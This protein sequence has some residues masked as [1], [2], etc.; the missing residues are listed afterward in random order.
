MI[1]VNRMTGAGRVAVAMS[2]GVDSSVTAALLKDQGYEVI[3]ISMRVWDPTAFF[4]GRE[5]EAQT[6]C[7]PDDVR[8]AG[9]IADQL[10]IPFYV[11]NFEEAFRSL[12]VDDF[13]SEY[14]R[15]RTPNPCARCNRLVKFGL[16]LDK[17]VELGADSMATGHYARIEQG[18]DG[19]HHLL[20]GVDP[21]KD[22]S[23][24][25]FGLT[26][27]Q[28]SRSLFPLGALTKPEVRELANRY[29]LRVAEKK[30]SQEICF[31]PDDDYVRFIEA[32]QDPGRLSGDIVTREGT[33]VGRHK[34]THRYTVGQ[35]RGLGI[36]WRE[37]LYVLA[38]DAVRRRVIVG[39][40][41]ELCHSG[42]EAAD[43]NWIMPAPKEELVT[44]CRIRYRHQ[45]VPC[46][47][48][49]LA[50]NRVTVHFDAPEKSITPGQAVVFYDGDRVLGGGWIERAI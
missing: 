21:K 50:D 16:L 46:R 48:V 3:G 43:M 36:A 13:V 40:R 17:A 28:L 5:C 1:E 4:A 27:A 8:D 6:C 26:Q 37:P 19:F 24:F 29:G 20:K 34:G 44:T 42:L 35:R 45:P 15:G 38:V 14:Y 23:Y 47:V 12:V 18:E 2:G 33:V 25:L 10:G 11:V 30:E 7:S 22:Q 49:P 31:I 9:R 32:E 41:E 39:P